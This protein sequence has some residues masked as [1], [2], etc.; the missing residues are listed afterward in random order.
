MNDAGH[1]HNSSLALN[2]LEMTMALA[3]R[4]LPQAVLQKYLPPELILGKHPT[5]HL[6]VAEPLL[7]TAVL[8]QIARE[9][10]RAAVLSSVDPQ[11]RNWPDFRRRNFPKQKSRTV[12][13]P[14]SRSDFL[15]ALKNTI[16]SLDS[17]LDSNS[18]L[19]PEF[20]SVLPLEADTSVKDQIQSCQKR[21]NAESGH[22]IP[23]FTPIGSLRGP[24]AIIFGQ[25][26]RKI[27]DNTTVALEERLP[28]ELQDLG[29]S[30]ENT[31]IW[32][33]ELHKVLLSDVYDTLL[34]ATLHRNYQ[35]FTQSILS[36]SLAKVV[37]V[38]GA[39]ADTSLSG[40]EHKC[41]LSSKILISVH[42]HNIPIR[43][44][45]E[46]QTVLR[47]FYFLPDFQSLMYG[48]N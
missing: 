27:T 46:K 17:Q 44:E 9:R 47:I 38:C 36:A 34:M 6:N 1:R 19:C 3:F 33:G 2:I 10:V 18:F 7:Q 39:E 20:D 11:I 31:L 15:T 16:N 48:Y 8:G 32:P 14:P 28:F 41:C 43:V 25:P 37:L 21:I 22:K 45:Y 30:V 12:R 29:L 13:T 24:I 40:Y 4:S 23:L 5:I 42:G 35:E 26:D